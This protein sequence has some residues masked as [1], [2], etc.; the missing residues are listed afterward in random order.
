MPADGWVSKVLAQALV[1]GRVLPVDVPGWVALADEVGPA[2]AHL[3]VE[4]LGADEPGSVAAARGEV[5]AAARVAASSGSRASGR[6]V[7]VVAASPAARKSGHEVRVA[8]AAGSGGTAVST[9]SALRRQQLVAAAGKQIVNQQRRPVAASAV[10]QVA[11]AD[12]VEAAWKDGRIPGNLVEHWLSSLDSKTGAQL[13]E[14]RADLAR[15]TPRPRPT[16][17][18]VASRAAAAATQSVARGDVVLRYPDGREVPVSAGAAAGVGCCAAGRGVDVWR[19]CPAAVHGERGGS[20]APAQAAG[21]GAGGRGGDVRPWPGAGDDPV[22][23]GVRADRGGLGR[24]WDRHV[25]D[26][27][28]VADGLTAAMTLPL[29]RQRPRPLAFCGD[30][31]TKA[32]QAGAPAAR[33]CSSGDLRGCGGRR[34]AGACCRCTWRVVV[35]VWSHHPLRRGLP[36]RL[37]QLAVS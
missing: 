32:P 12:L 18:P 17:A 5:L 27:R 22:A 6:K 2:A 30:L 7:R 24:L 36:W 16:A 34:Q 29:R 8:A 19:W 14:A 20:T 11:N 28:R 35:R 9:T 3:V 13:V 10:E 31:G 1:D 4:R 37:E 15:R 23:R 21:V 33:R 25:V 26:Q